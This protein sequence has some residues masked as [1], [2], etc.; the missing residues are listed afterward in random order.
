MPQDTKVTFANNQ[1]IGLEDRTLGHV[2]RPN[3]HSI[4]KTPEFLVEYYINRDGMRDE[5]LHK[6]TKLAD[7]TRVLL[8][9]DSFTYGEANHYD[10][11]WPVI[12]ERR[13]LEQGY[14]ADIIK[15]G[16]PGFDTTKELQ[17]LKRLYPIY[18]P[19][20]VVFVFLPN[21]LFTNTPLD[22]N[23][24]TNYDWVVRAGAD[25]KIQLHSLILFK[26]LLL[27][28][29]YIYTQLYYITPRSQYFI[30]P[31]TTQVDNQ[32]ELTKNLLSEAAA[33]CKERNAEFIV[34][35]IPQ[36]F[37]VIVKSNNGSNDVDVDMIDSIFLEY[38][39]EAGFLW[40]PSLTVLTD[41]YKT[42]GTDQY[43]RLD[44]HLNK[45]GNLI[46]GNYFSGVFVEYLNRR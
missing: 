2:L 45:N 32:I 15:A 14:D 35:S 41:K 13:I 25:K 30:H 42:T 34:L 43:F 40:I 27:E 10:D 17:Y 12:F 44:G 11:I 1:S 39:R 31:M 3:S 20:I 21:D 8:I 5:K 4:V 37:Q 22:N 26:R 33:Y 38:S 24:S 46:I 9:G 16:V 28:I 23:A 19:D 7:T 36:Q 18:K 29:D 6:Q